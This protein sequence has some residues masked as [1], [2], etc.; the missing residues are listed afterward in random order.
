MICIISLLSLWLIPVHCFQ[1]SIFLGSSHLSTFNQHKPLLRQDGRCQL[2]QNGDDEKSPT[3]TTTEDGSEGKKSDLS[4]ILPDWMSRW[5]R[6][7]DNDD[8]D[9]SGTESPFEA[10]TTTTTTTTVTAEPMI[11]T[12]AISNGVLT[13]SPIEQAKSL[14]AQAETARLE[15]ELMEAELTLQKVARLE[16]KLEKAK[17]KEAVD[18]IQRQ[19]VALQAKWDK[20]NDTSVVAAN[21]TF[22]ETSYG[23][24]QLSESALK[25]EVPIPRGEYYS[26]LP[27]LVEPF[28]QKQFEQALEDFENGP[29]ALKRIITTQVGMEY[30]KDGKVNATAVAYRFDAMRRLDFSFDEGER[31]SFNR[32]QIDEMKKRLKAGWP[33]SSEEGFVSDERLKDAAKGNE[34]QLALLW[35]E[36][37]YFTLKYGLSVENITEMVFQD[38]DVTAEITRGLQEL[39]FQAVTESSL[40]PCTRKED[41]SPT[42]EQAQKLCT[43]VLPKTKFSSTS[44]PIEIPGGFLVQGTSKAKDGDDLIASI[45]EQIERSSLRGKVTVCFLRDYTVFVTESAEEI[46]ALE[47]GNDTILFVGGPDIAREPQKV[48]LSLTSA[49]GLATCWYLSLYPFLL[50]PNVAK[51]VDE[52]LALVDAGMTADLAWLSDLSFPL[53]TTFVGI[54]LFHEAG[55]RLVA[56][57]N[58]V[59][60]TVPTFVPSIITGVTSVATSFKK[61]PKNLQA[62]FDFSV[63]GPLLGMIGSIAAIALGTQLTMRTDA[64]NLPA[65]PLEILRQS[66][67]GGGIVESILGS[68]ILSVP[69]A[70]LGSQ[71]VAG[72]TIPLHPVAIA[73]YISLVVNALSMLPIGTTDGGRVALALFGRESKQAIGG[74]AFSA[75]LFFGI[76]GSDLFL[77]YFAFCLAFQKGNEIPCR[78]EVDTVDFSRVIIA[79]IAYFLAL[80]ALIPFE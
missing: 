14:R 52:Q 25:K 80:L 30:P 61:P 65:L 66:S 33:S 45:D 40:P 54:Q 27:D 43:D 15:A 68:G 73:G 44:K 70:A 20:K 67:L 35:L 50:N 13:T 26:N 79:T 4:R 7:Q 60:P 32:E 18:N 76:Q 46:A 1:P 17:N 29:E 39:S 16:Q 77:F 78:N 9:E 47:S 51:R 41:Q 49:M 2:S 11:R 19:I 48:L 3:S 36:N 74:L 12:P 22:A 38:K 56:S 24:K 72:M 64:T 34:T 21:K 69:D 6:G 75:I 8:D 23:K 10:E 57:F 58:G 53:F 71:A 5:T 37:E 28:D 42:L 59:E 63:A 62:M 31:P 55:H